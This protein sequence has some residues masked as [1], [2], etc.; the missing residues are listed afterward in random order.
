MER[1][2][3]GRLWPSLAVELERVLSTQASV[4]SSV[5]GDDDPHLP[6][7]RWDDVGRVREVLGTVTGTCDSARGG[8]PPPPASGPASFPPGPLQGSCPRSSPPSEPRVRGVPRTPSPAGACWLAPRGRQSSQ[9]GRS[10]KRGDT[11]RPPTVCVFFCSPRPFV[12]QNLNR[13]Y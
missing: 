7:S 8:L 4:S 11:W 13:F 6:G 9:P 12:S 10:V 5:E 1:W 3:R 2:L